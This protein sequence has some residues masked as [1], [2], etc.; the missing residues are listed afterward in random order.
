MTQMQ[1]RYTATPTDG[2]ELSLFTITL[3]IVDV[4]GTTTARTMLKTKS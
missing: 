4:A 1:L 3:L 2:A